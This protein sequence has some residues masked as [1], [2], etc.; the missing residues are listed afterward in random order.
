M[1]GTVIKIGAGI[2]GLTAVSTSS[3]FIRGYYN[4]ER[5]SHRISK[6][7]LTLLSS[8]DSEEEW[9][10]R[11]KEY[12]KAN[13][14]WKLTDYEQNKS[15]EN[16]APD[17]FKNK[18]LNSTGL[19]IE[20]QETFAAEF[21]KYCTKSFKVTD[22]LSSKEKGITILQEGDD[23]NLWNSAWEKYVKDNEGKNPLTIGNWPSVKRNTKQLPSDYKERCKIVKG[24][25]VRNTRET[26]YISVKNWCTKAQ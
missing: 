16:K 12:I 21:E 6:R 1:S 3:Y 24:M 13:N 7:D 19:A 5:I 17:N 4:T 9:A 10:K 18:C 8:K 22:L 20:G 23:V 2:A 25:E 15:N 11:W 26:N 14:P